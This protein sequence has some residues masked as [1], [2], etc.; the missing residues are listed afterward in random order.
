MKITILFFLFF[1]IACKEN[2]VE[3]TTKPATYQTSTKIR[4]G[5][6][7]QELERL[8]FRRSYAGH[9]NLSGKALKAL[10]RSNPALLS[11]DTSELVKK[12][13]QI[14][15]VDDQDLVLSAFENKRIKKAFLDDEKKI[16][17]TVDYYPMQNAE[18]NIAID[19]G[20][21]K[22]YKKIDLNVDYLIGIILKDIDDDK[23][24]EILIVTVGYIMNGDNFDLRILKYDQ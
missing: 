11:L 8:T 10:Y 3:R 4:P 20:V 17:I 2:K 24:K 1:L 9:E 5:N 22:L 13:D 19:N 14:G 16:G 15:L 18:I 6:S 7:I 12:L 23:N 21:E